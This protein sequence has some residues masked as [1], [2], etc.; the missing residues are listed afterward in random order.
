VRLAAAR[1][2]WHTQ[3]A[4]LVLRTPWVLSKTAGRFLIVIAPTLDV[5]VVATP[6]GHRVQQSLGQLPQG[7]A[8]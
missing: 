1:T 7:S 6:W 2:D 4:W 5:L 3:A 8:G